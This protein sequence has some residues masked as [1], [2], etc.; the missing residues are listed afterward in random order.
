MNI[1]DIS[2]KFVKY[3]ITKFNLIIPGY[4]EPYKVD[5][6]YLG[7]FTIEKNY[8]E[9]YLPYI[10][11]NI[12]LPKKV[13]QD[14]LLHHEDIYI[15]L[16]LEYAQFEDIYESDP[17][18]IYYSYGDIIDQRFYAMIEDSTPKLTLG[19]TGDEEANTMDHDVADQ[20]INPL[21]L[22]LYN[23][24][25][26]FGTNQIVNAVLK[27]ASI[28]DGVT[29][30]LQTAG[31]KKALMSPAQRSTKMDQLIITPITYFKQM[32][33]LCNSY[34]MHD[35]GT[36]IFF[37]Y[38]IVYILDKKLGC[39]AYYPNEYKTTYLVSFNQSGE[40]NAMKTGFYSNSKERYSAVNISGNNFS[41]TGESVSNQQLVGNNAVIIDSNTGKVSSITSKAQVSSQS[42]SKV[43]RIIVRNSG[44]AQDNA[45]K[46]GFEQS[47]RVL[48]GIFRDINIRALTPNKD[49]IFT[50]DNSKYN[51]Y[52]GHYRILN[53]SATFTKDGE[54]WNNT[55]SAKFIGGS[56]KI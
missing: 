8:D 11:F 43:K 45:I 10:E 56:T 25:H 38:D 27:N 22:A 14:V 2:M 32:D 18:N 24:T 28:A 49:F 20:V 3:R 4:S 50:T 15:D 9:W 16:K 34:R 31:V 35:A 48:T 13:K 37:D 5:S 44:D 26:L 19:T 55:T 21:Q 17:E 46:E 54:L 39:T 40:A 53:C 42:N 7:D 47:N 52:C 23:P 36:T 1:Q 41:I 29:Y 33:R 12:V 30:M 51:K 6:K